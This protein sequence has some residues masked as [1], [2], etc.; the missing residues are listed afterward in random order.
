ML[1]GEA[2]GTVEDQTGLPFVGPAGHV[3]DKLCADAG[4]DLTQCFITNPV[5]CHQ[6]QNRL[7][8]AEELAA[9]RP[10]LMQQI[11]LVKPAVIILLGQVALER[12]WHGARMGE[13]KGRVWRG[14]GHWFVVTYHPS[15][16]LHE[17]QLYDGVVADLKRVKEFI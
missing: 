5:K 11:A 10:Y 6:P 7:P 3:L 14:D 9:C 2:P 12:F 1:V 4:I 16:L 8:L 17:S 13:C 15:K